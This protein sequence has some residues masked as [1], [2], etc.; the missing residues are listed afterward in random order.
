[1]RRA[2]LLGVLA[3][4]AVSP[5]ASATTQDPAT[6]AAAVHAAA[7]ATAPADATI[8]VGTVQGATVMPACGAAL[9][10]EVTG[11]APYE[12][13]TVRCQAPSWTLYVAVTVAA[14]EMVEVAARP[15]AAGASL[16]PADVRLQREPVAAYAG[17]QVYYAPDDL[18][19]ATAGMNLPAGAI[20][21]A[22]AIQAPLLVRAGQTTMVTVISG[23]VSVTVNAVADESG[24]RGDTILMT[25]ASSGQRFHALITAQGPVVRLQ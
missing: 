8:T 17:R 18:I 4:S 23:G 24:R 5:A 7:A 1:M 9:A 15:I 14:T 12:Q 10:V 16:A 22:T 6:V 20:L 3:A 19:G 21:T 13:A 2:V 11:V 25:N